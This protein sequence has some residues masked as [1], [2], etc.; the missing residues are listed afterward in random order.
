MLYRGLSTINMKAD[1]L[2]VCILH[3]L[4]SYY[5][6]I[7]KKQRNPPSAWVATFRGSNLLKR[8]WEREKAHGLW[9]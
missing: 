7:T 3:F 8:G 5:Y 4:H 2:I 6:G 9:Y 1:F